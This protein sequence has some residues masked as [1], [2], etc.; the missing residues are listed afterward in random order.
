MIATIDFP[1]IDPVL[2]SFGPF[3]IRWYALAYIGGLLIA[4]RYCRWLAARPPQSVSADAFDDFLL[5]RYHMFLMVYYHYRPVVFEEMM[6][7][8]F[9]EIGGHAVPAEAGHRRPIAGHSRPFLLD[10][11]G[12]KECPKTAKPRKRDGCQKLFRI[13]HLELLHLTEVEP[14]ETF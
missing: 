8:W 11:I 10:P 2:I 5:S 6:L 12:I 4:W 3:A 1:A 9:D 7:R 13:R 14:N